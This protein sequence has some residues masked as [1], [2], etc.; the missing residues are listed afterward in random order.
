MKETLQNPSFYSSSEAFR[1]EMLLHERIWH[2]VGFVGA[3]LPHKDSFIRVKIVNRDVLVVRNGNIFSAF[4]NIC[5][6]RG[7]PFTLK[8]RGK[9]STFTCMY[10]GLNFAKDGKFNATNSAHEFCEN[11]ANYFQ[12]DCLKLTQVPL[13]ICGEAIFLSIQPALKLADQFDNDLLEQLSLLKVDHQY[14]FSAWTEPFNYKLNY[15]NVNDP[16][17]VPHVHQATFMQ[18]LDYDGHIHKNQK[19]IDFNPSHSKYLLKDKTTPSISE[20]SGLAFTRIDRDPPW[21]SNLINDSPNF[22]DDKYINFF[23]FPGT[24]LFSVGGTHF[25]LQRYNPINSE[26]FIYELS[27]FLPPMANAFEAAPVLKELFEAELDTIKEDSAILKSVH[28]NM[29]QIHDPQNQLFHGD[30]EKKISKLSS[31]Y[32]YIHSTSPL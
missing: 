6:H 26:E 16:L 27:Y 22:E 2:C 11:P 28:I 30:Y 24:N 7:G 4:L 8:D 1:T 14:V 5:P 25:G 32:N 19:N 18:M 10:H 17:H 3:L 31:Y 12:L 9:L 13:E 23:L 15:E 21:W 29:K 20:L